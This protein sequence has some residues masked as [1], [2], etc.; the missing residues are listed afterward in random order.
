MHAT[1]SPAPPRRRRFSRWRFLVATAAAGAVCFLVLFL[2]A[3]GVVAVQALTKPPPVEE[4]DLKPAV[5]EPA[6]D[7]VLKDLDG[8]E[9]R[10][11]DWLGKT[12]LVLEFGS[13]T[14]PYCVQ[15]ADGM[16]KIDNK[17]KDR[18][19]FLFIYCKEAHPD[20][21]DMLLPGTK[22]TLPA[23][24]QTSAGEDRSNRARSYC[25]AKQPTA[26]VLVDVDGPESVQELYGGE[27]NQVVVIDAQGRVAFKEGTGRL[28]GGLDAFLQDHFPA[29]KLRLPVRH[30]QRGGLLRISAGAL[31]SPP[32]V[33]RKS[34]RGCENRPKP[35]RFTLRPARVLFRTP[36][37]RRPCVG[38]G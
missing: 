37:L 34:E 32:V 6:P 9:C 18:V 10:L 4:A 14:C 36:G 26:R 16:D 19:E 17:Y 12:P 38:S 24:P 28:P 3:A 11:A 15:A 1:Q 22:E 35:V 2:A 20:A 13:A 5:G 27:P 30:L 21:P 7:F 23:L 25:S 31:L 29:H 33:G 8:K